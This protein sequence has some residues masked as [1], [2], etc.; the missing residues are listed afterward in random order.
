MPNM[1]KHFN[2]LHCDKVLDG[3]LN[4]KWKESLEPKEPKQ[5]QCRSNPS[6]FAWFRLFNMNLLLSGSPLTVDGPQHLG[7]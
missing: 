1:F 4:P 6:R 3:G 5:V 2:V 7:C